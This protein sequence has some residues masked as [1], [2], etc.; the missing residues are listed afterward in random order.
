MDIYVNLDSSW[1]V[2]Q[3]FQIDSLPQKSPRQSKIVVL[4]NQHTHLKITLA[5]VHLVGGRFDENN[6]LSGFLNT[7]MPTIQDLK[8][9]LLERL[10]HDYHVDP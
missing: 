9:E 4:Q 2:V 3:L 8:T 1:K 6:Q 7:D 5:N 10:L